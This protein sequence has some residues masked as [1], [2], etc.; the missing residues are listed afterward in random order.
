MLNDSLAAG[1]RAPRERACFR[2]GEGGRHPEKVMASGPAHTE[3][4]EPGQHHT[5]SL[6]SGYAP[7]RVNGEIEDVEDGRLQ[8][9]SSTLRPAWWRAAVRRPEF[10]VVVCGAAGGLLSGFYGVY[11]E[12]ASPAGYGLKWLYSCFLGM[13]SAFVGVFLL[14]NSDVSSSG[15]LRRTLAFALMC[16]FAWRP[17]LEA[18]TALVKKHVRDD[19]LSEQIRAHEEELTQAA[20]APVAIAG[21]TAELLRDAERVDSAALKARA[22]F[23]RLQ[24]GVRSWLR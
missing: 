19:Q 1:P 18:G 2:H 9:Q 16:G 8:Q 13:G 14:A 6:E 20:S 15:S 4:F 21:T 12:E 23:R 22:N 11:V 10:W 17:V 5:D 7:A 24:R 3:Q